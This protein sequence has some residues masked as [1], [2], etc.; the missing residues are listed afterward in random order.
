MAVAVKRVRL[1]QDHLL[2]PRQALQHIAL[3]LAHPPTL[4]EGWR[5]PATSRE[6]P[7]AP[8]EHAP[9]QPDIEPSQKHITV[10]NPH[11]Q[12]KN[13]EILHCKRFY[14]T[15]QASTPRLSSLICSV[16]PCHSAAFQDPATSALLPAQ[17]RWQRVESLFSEIKEQQRD[18]PFNWLNAFPSVVVFR[19]AARKNS[20]FSR[21]LAHTE[22]G[23]L[24]FWCHAEVCASQ[25]FWPS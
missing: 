12:L 10:A 14:I 25:P 13:T 19:P 20:L 23:R 24:T 15:V 8:T 6:G 4:V 2:H 1:H 5:V 7:A 17:I 3:V 18:F 11:P 22:S 16:P 9:I 21:L